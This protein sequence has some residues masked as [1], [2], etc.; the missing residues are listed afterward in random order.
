MN[1][2]CCVDQPMAAYNFHLSLAKAITIWTL[3]PFLADLPFVGK[4]FI[5]D[6]Q[7]LLLHKSLHMRPEANFSYTNRSN[8]SV[9]A[10]WS[11][12]LQASCV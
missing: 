10:K 1:P 8:D 5:A 4:A 6:A 9:L 3:F 12:L 7:G 11:D 2:I